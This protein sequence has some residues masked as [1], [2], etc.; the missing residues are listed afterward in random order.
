M[1]VSGFF[2]YNKL[3]YKKKIYWDFDYLN[4]ECIIMLYFV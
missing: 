4:E 1:Y 2:L 3:Y